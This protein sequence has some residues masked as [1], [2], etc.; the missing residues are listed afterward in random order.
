[1][2][3]TDFDIKRIENQFQ[4]VLIEDQDLFSHVQEVDVSD[5]LETLLKTNVP[6]AQAIGTEKAK[7][8]LI[9]INVM[10]ELKRQRNI[11]LF[12]GIE[13]SVD[14]AEGLNGFCDFL[15][16]KFP[17]QLFVK[18]PVIAIVEAKNEN[19]IAGLGQCAA[20]MIAARIFNARENQPYETI[21]GA[22]TTGHSWK[23]LKLEANHLMID[24]EDYYI[25]NPR[26][27]VAILSAMVN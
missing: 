1:M 2:A 15:I 10:L 21:Y 7:S 20:E 3:Y 26:K 4:L 8:E 18:A 17:E 13:F 11:G 16:S 19:I 23:F 5:F 27:I 12:S 9:T 22:V 14:K 25:K 6:L 24:L